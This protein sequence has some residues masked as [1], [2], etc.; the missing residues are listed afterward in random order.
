MSIGIEHRK[1]GEAADQEWNAYAKKGYTLAAAHA[2][3]QISGRWKAHLRRSND[4]CQKKKMPRWFLL[5]EEGSE[6]EDEG[7]VVQLWVKLQRPA[8]TFCGLL[9]ALRRLAGEQ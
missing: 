6:E 8:P 7:R 3:H 4:C 1:R 5:L 2:R 9:L